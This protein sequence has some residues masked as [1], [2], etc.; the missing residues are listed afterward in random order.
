M[1][2]RRLINRVI[3]ESYILSRASENKIS[4]MMVI[5]FRLL[6]YDHK[7]LV[8]KWYF[9]L[10]H[11]IPLFRSIKVFAERIVINWMTHYISWATV[12]TARCCGNHEEVI[13]KLL[14]SINM[15]V[16]VCFFICIVIWLDVRLLMEKLALFKTRSFWIQKLIFLLLNWNIIWR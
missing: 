6:R 16:D 2:L 4:T 1:H 10:T 11:H 12:N 13:L 7:L 8:L 14:F 9:L 3:V 15:L 5:I